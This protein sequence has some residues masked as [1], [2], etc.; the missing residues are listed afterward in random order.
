MRLK[1][2]GS[3]ANSK[4]SDQPFLSYLISYKISSFLANFVA[5]QITQEWLIGS[6]RVGR[7]PI[8]F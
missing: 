5:D 4:R 6:L 8:G 3:S 2:D 7:G 1:A